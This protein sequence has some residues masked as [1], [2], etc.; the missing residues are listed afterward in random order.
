MTLSADD[1]EQRCREINVW[2]DDARFVDRVAEI[3]AA[4]MERTPDDVLGIAGGLI[5]T[6]GAMGSHMSAQDRVVLARQMMNSAKRL[7][8]DV[9]GATLQ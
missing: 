3:I 2:L 1:A 5:A 4:A 7:D 6:T 9:I 8:G